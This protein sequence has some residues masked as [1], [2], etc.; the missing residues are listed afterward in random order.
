MS[1]PNVSGALRGWTKKR[2]VKIIEKTVV[3][4]MTTYRAEIIRLDIFVAPLQPEKIRRKPEEQRAW[5]WFDILIRDGGRQLKIDDRIEVGGIVY[6]I[7]SVQPW[8]D[9]GYRRY[10][11][12]ENYT[13]IDTLYAVTYDGNG[14]DGGTKPKTYAY[15]SGATP[16]VSA[17]TFTLTDHT[18]VE[19]NT[20]ADGTGVGYDAG[21]V[22]GIADAVTLYAIWEAVPNLFKEYEPNINGRDFVVSD[23]HG[24]YTDLEKELEITKDEI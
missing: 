8:D 6:K 24:C 12:T 2:T 3:N 10:E 23:I 15:Q 18:F 5:K 22:L 7:D 11:A 21:D 9:G 4:F 16:S 13:G 1:I 19:W 17:N 14:A 20:A